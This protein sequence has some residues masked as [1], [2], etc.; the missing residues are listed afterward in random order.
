MMTMLG[1]LFG[2]VT[3]SA[4]FRLSTPIILT[5]VGGSFNKHT[6]VFC[7]AFECFMLSAAFFAAW[8]SYLTGSPYMGTLFAI[9]AGL[10]LAAI[11][12][13]FVL[14]FKA[15][16]M[17][18][19]IA[20]NFGAWAVTTLLLT[21]IFGVRG[22]FHSP[23]IVNFSPIDIPVLREIPYINEVLNNQI[24]LVYIA[25]ISVVVGTIIMYKTPFGLRLRTIGINEIGAQTAGV[26]ILK[27]KWIGLAIMGIMSGLGGA[28]L[29][30]SGLSMFSENMSSGR[31]FL[32]FAAILVSKGN[33]VKAALISI[34]FAYTNALTFT[35]TSYGIPSQLLQMFPFIA[36]IIVL[37]IG[38]LR[39]LSLTPVIEA[40]E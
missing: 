25:Y 21:E 3:W 37:M 38:N 2:S 31:G 20:M 1:I 22:Y 33:P 17:I 11:F 26:N 10:L 13:M 39:N 6:G 4:T 7:I 19:S 18:V 29:P 23:K 40:S 27:Y 14:N 32:A 15:N 28:Y 35:L 12:G 8:G 30:L 9:L 5:S 36:V 16:P 24:I 34:L